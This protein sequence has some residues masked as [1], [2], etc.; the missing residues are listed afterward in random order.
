MPFPKKYTAG[1]KAK[2]KKKDSKKPIA[3]RAAAV[4]A[5]RK[6]GKK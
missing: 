6:R 3:K 1:E 5:A 2:M 4:A